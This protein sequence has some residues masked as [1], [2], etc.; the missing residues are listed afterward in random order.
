MNLA[1]LSVLYGLAG[2]L[3]GGIVYHRRPERGLSALGA[4]AL[5]VPLWPLWL[6][7]LFASSHSP[8]RR[9]P[10]AARSAS[11]EAEA[12]LL[13]G[14]E[15]VRGTPL[16]PLLPRAAVDRM[17]RELRRATERSAELEQLLAKKGFDRAEA[18]LRLARLQQRSASPRTLASARLHL[19]NVARLQG[20][21]GRDR[22][23][24]E[25]LSELIAAL[26]T[27][28]VFARYSGS[29]PGE[30]SDIVTEV[31]ARVEMLGTSSDGA[32][33]TDALASPSPASSCNWPSTS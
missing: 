19:E 6:P 30:A 17:L 2:A 27:Q 28:L 4:A 8:G 7:V 33:D 9:G 12:A 32:F 3:S 20:L 26:R 21:A 25:E 24:L 29:S 14:H 13:E 18:E 5:A 15:A 1:D 31:W 10:G 11:S 16:E 22:R 23:A